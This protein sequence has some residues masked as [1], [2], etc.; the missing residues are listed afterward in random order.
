V[1][2]EFQKEGPTNHIEG[3]CNINLQQG[4]RAMSSMQQFGRGL[5]RTEVIM[6]H[7][8]LD[9]GSLVWPYQAVDQQS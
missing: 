6:Q 8:T 3:L 9:E 7:V 4:T 1:T 5:D 2:E